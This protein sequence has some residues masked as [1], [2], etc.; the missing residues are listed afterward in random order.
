MASRRNKRRLRSSARSA[1]AV[2]R[3]SE[4]SVLPWPL[5]S[6]SDLSTSFS[7]DEGRIEAD[8]EVRGVTGS[9]PKGPPAALARPGA[10]QRPQ[11]AAPDHRSDGWRSRRRG[12]EHARPRPDQREPLPEADPVRSGRDERPAGP[13]WKRFESSG[14]SRGDRR[15]SGG[16]RFGRLHFV[17]PCAVP[18]WSRFVP[19]GFTPPR[20]DELP[21]CPTRTSC[22]HSLYGTATSRTSRR[23]WPSKVRCSTVIVGL[24]WDAHFFCTD[25][26]PRRRPSCRMSVLQ[27]STSLRK[28]VGDRAKR[29]VVLR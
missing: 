23:T 8:I 12:P 6:S 22:S 19:F 18:S 13:D 10:L 14:L 11:E 20:E 3:P 24:I 28:S 16:R 2:S 4:R 29:G 7:S 25:F 15:A 27:A 1:S 5:P 9:R 17:S 21:H 26:S